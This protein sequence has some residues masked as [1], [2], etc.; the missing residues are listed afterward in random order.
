MYHEM[1]ASSTY[2]LHRFNPYLLHSAGC[3]SLF[4]SMTE[5]DPDDDEYVH[6][7]KMIEAVDE[8]NGALVQVYEAIDNAKMRD[9]KK[10]GSVSLFMS[11]KY[12]EIMKPVMSKW[13]HLGAMD[14]ASRS[15]PANRMKKFADERYNVDIDGWDLV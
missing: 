11:R 15:R 3:W 14:T 12:N 1:T 8:L 4:T 9:M 2:R 10:A 5:E 6:P 7:S 13:S